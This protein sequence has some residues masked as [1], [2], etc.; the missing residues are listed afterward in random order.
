MGGGGWMGKARSRRER[1]RKVVWKFGLRGAGC[2]A[3]GGPAFASLKVEHSYVL[4][5]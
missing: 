2:F 4:V 1:S 5:G 3:A